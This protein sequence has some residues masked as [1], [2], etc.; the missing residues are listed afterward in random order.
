[1]NSQQIL[2]NLAKA[3]A[4]HVKWRSYAYG[5]VSGLDITKDYNPMEH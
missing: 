3:K 4:A 2:S 5:L 1:M